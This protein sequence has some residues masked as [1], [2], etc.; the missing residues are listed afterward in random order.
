MV[1]YESDLIE[2][3]SA[4]QLTARLLALL[5]TLLTVAGW[6]YAFYFILKHVVCG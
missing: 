1:E 5:V 2:R 4:L 6:S 3:E